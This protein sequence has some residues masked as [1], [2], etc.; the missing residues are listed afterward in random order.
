[1]ILKSYF[2]FMKFMLLVKRKIGENCEIKVFEFDVYNSKYVPERYLEFLVNV[3]IRI[4]NRNYSILPDF[5][6]L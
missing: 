6:I 2:K 1:M 4:N 3:T 5:Y